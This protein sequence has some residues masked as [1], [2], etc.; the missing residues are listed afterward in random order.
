MSSEERK[1]R[2]ARE[3]YGRH[4]PALPEGTYQSHV[5]LLVKRYKYIGIAL[6]SQEPGSGGESVLTC[7]LHQGEARKWN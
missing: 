1:A 4:M 5:A 3:E 2:E 6:V 7:S